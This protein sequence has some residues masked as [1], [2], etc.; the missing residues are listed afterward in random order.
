MVRPLGRRGIGHPVAFQ[1]AGVVAGHGLTHGCWDP[2]DA[3]HP[4]GHLGSAAD[5][6]A[7]HRALANL[8]QQGFNAFEIP[9]FRQS[10][11]DGNSQRCASLNSI[12]SKIIAQVIQSSHVIQAAQSQVGS[13]QGDGLILDCTN[14]LISIQVDIGVAAGN[15]ATRH[16]ASADLSP[17]LQDGLPQLFSVKVLNSLETALRETLGRQGAHGIH[18]GCDRGRAVGVGIAFGTQ[19]WVFHDLFREAFGG[20]FKELL[21]SKRDFPFRSF[22]HYYGL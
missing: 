6:L 3:Q 20:S 13:Q 1:A 21:I 18:R 5:H 14:D 12:Q 16:A 17:T 4:A 19:F 9:K 8:P 7:Q 2:L 15:H 10:G 22:I 11:L